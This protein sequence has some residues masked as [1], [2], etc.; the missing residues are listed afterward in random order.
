MD[1]DHLQEYIDNLEIAQEHAKSKMAKK[2]TKG[3][4][5]CSPGSCQEGA[6]A[7]FQEAAR[8]LAAA[9]LAAEEARCLPAI[10]AIQDGQAA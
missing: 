7:A 8:V 5:S 10:M 6:A 2:K 9:G 1:L 3:S 4:R